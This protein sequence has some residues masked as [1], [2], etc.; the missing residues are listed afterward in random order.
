MRALAKGPDDRFPT[1]NDI[2]AAIEAP[3]PPVRNSSARPEASSQPGVQV[4][5][6]SRP[7]I[8]SSRTTVDPHAQTAAQR[9]PAG[10]GCRGRSAGRAS[11]EPAAGAR[12]AVRGGLGAVPR[13]S[14]WSAPRPS[15]SV[16][17][18]A[19]ARP[20]ARVGGHRPARLGCDASRSTQARHGEPQAL[21]AYLGGMTALR[22]GDLS[23]AERLFNDAVR[24]DAGIAGARLRVAIVQFYPAGGCK[25][26]RRSTRPSSCAQA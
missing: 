5:K 17:T 13:P 20:G 23:S 2:L 3:R 15:R 1:M 21:A 24:L 18:R 10:P 11:G 4:S 9:G 19:A 12:G 25:P 6:S 16:R 22:D 8:P 7:G 26:E 14:R